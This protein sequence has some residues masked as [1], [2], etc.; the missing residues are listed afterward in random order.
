MTISTVG[1][2]KFKTHAV[3]ISRCCGRIYCFKMTH[4]RCD[5]EIFDDQESA[6]DYI[7]E[8]FATIVYGVNLEEE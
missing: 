8:P 7:L 6:A 5:L 2:I 3:H 1:Y 4:T